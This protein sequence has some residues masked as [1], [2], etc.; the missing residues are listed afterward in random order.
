MDSIA[1]PVGLIVDFPFSG[2]PSPTGTRVTFSDRSEGVYIPY[3]SAEENKMKWFALSDQTNWASQVLRDAVECSMLL[4]DG[5]IPTHIQR[6]LLV[7]CIG[8]EHIISRDVFQR[9][10]VSM[11]KKRAHVQ[12]VLDEQRRQRLRGV[13]SSDCLALVSMRSSKGS[14]S[15]ARKVAMTIAS[16]P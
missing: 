9:L 15:R 1:D 6:A 8:L 2:S 14:R 4:F 13:S 16:I 11:E 10:R 5:N 7:R 12:S 3:P